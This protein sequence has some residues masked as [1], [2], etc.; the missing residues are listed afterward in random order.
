MLLVL[1]HDLNQ[2]CV[3]KARANL[4]LAEAEYREMAL[5]LINT[6]LRFY[7][8]LDKMKQNQFRDFFSVFFAAKNSV[9]NKLISR[10]ED[11]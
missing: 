8:T 11:E 5:F 2:R 9:S 1:S 6:V 10:F 3:E 7:D 4:L